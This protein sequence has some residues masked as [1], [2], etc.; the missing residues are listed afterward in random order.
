MKKVVTFNTFFQTIHFILF[1][2]NIDSNYICLIKK[3][4]RTQRDIHLSWYY[5]HKSLKPV[6][7]DAASLLKVVSHVSQ[8]LSYLV[9]WVGR[10]RAHYMDMF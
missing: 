5:A 10:S 1:T 4:K 8:F 2:L 9:V 3:A 6:T 7:Y